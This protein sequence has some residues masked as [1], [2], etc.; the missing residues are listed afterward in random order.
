MSIETYMW[1]VW[2][3]AV[4]IAVIVEAVTNDLVSVWFAAGA[5]IALVVSFIPNVPWWVEVIIFVVISASA[6]I[7]LRPFLKKF[8]K[9]DLVKTNVDEIIGKKAVVTI[10]GNL[11]QP[12]E[13]L[14]K[15]K[16]WSAIPEKEGEELIEDEIVT[17]LAIQGVKLV[18]RKEEEK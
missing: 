3:A 2:L 8:M 16:K 18:V 10:A 9:H 5:L 7:L 6:F 1:I 14:K 12:G 15:K 11:R 17:V 4:V 13:V